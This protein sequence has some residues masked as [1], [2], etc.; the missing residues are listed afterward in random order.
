ML[1]TFTNA[2]N[3]LNGIV[4]GPP[5]LVLLMG[6]GVLLLFVTGGVQFR[7]IGTALG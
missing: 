6:T 3:W 1:E 2:N 4:W 5:M 7:H